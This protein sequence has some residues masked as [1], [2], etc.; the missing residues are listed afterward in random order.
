MVQKSWAGIKLEEMNDE[1]SVSLTIFTIHIL[2]GLGNRETHTQT[3]V[4]VASCKLAAYRQETVEPESH[5]HPERRTQNTLIVDGWY[6]YFVF[7]C[8]DS[9]M[10]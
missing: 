1:T 2:H 10:C 5:S 7:K 9:D 3:N 8:S 6:T 4:E